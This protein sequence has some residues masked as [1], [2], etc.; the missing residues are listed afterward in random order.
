VSYELNRKLAAKKPPLRTN[1]TVD[2]VTATILRGAM[3]TICFEAA[4]HLGRAAS[5]PMINASNE[6]NGAII[7]AHGRLA[8][9]SVGT[10]QLTFVTQM[11]VS[12]GL[13]NFE[14]Y[15][16]GPGDVFL[17]NDPDYGG[18]HLPD[19]CV[20]APAFDDD[21][22]LVLIQALQTHQ[23]DTGGKDPGG[24]SFD[25]QD[26]FAEGLAIPCIKL[27]HR[28]EPRYDILHMLERNNRF[29]TFSGDL[30]AMISAVQ[31]SVKKLEQMVRRWGTD[32]INAS[33]NFN[34]DLTEKLVREQVAKWPDGR[35]EGEAFIDH[36]TQGIKDIRVKAAVI[37]EGDQL[38]VDFTGTDDR[39]ELMCVWNTFA[40]SRSYSMMQLCYAMDPAIVKNEGVF[41]AMDLYFPEGSIAQPPPN[42]PAS[43]GSFH[44]AN[45]IAEAVG[46]AM[47]QLAPGRSAPQVYKIGMPMQVMGFDARGKM[48]MDQGVDCHVMDASAVAGLDGWGAGSHSLGNM[49]LQQAEDSESRFPV[50]NH[51][52]EM[53][54]DACG[55]GEW[56]GHPG[57]FNVKEVRDSLLAMTWTC[58][59][60]HPLQGLCGGDDA[61]AYACYFEWGTENERKIEDRAFEQLPAGAKIGYMHGGGAGFGSPMERDPE[62]VKED[63]LDE[64]VSM[65]AAREKYGVVLHGSLEDY[66]LTVDVNATHSLRKQLIT[67]QG[68]S[69]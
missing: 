52:R 9:A 55:A 12:Y 28:G 43:L 65:K 38:T 68:A 30:A 40:N 17:T 3:E 26:I 15:N 23:G 53:V 34:I 39:P 1:A 5:S 50:L 69:Q 36:D 21:G 31:L 63:V 35:Y 67:D 16:W 47:S 6:R 57:S 59:A 20:Y 8:G 22:K 48:W 7:D 32:T 58:S 37:I 24:Y 29:A 10:P 4:T 56:R 51:T 19:Y 41:H 62:A 64:Y 14:K 60:R 33:I 49:L 61:N 42:K 44:P 54:T 18:G 45:E 46:I 27:V 66:D 2:P 13:M 25:A 11:E